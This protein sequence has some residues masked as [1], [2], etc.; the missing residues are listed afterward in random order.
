MTIYHMNPT[1]LTI[2]RKLVL[3]LHEFDS[4]NDPSDAMLKSSIAAGWRDDIPIKVTLYNK[5]VVV[6]D[7]YRRLSAVLELL[8]EDKFHSDVTVEFVT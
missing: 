3:R 8:K 1:E 6:I 2:D 5:Q 4:R 7:G